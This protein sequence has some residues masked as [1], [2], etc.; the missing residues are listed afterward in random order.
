MAAAERLDLLLHGFLSRFFAI[1]ARQPATGAVTF[2]QMRVLWTLEPIQPATPGRIAGALGIGSSAATEI[3]ERLARAGYIQRAHSER[4][5]RHVLLRLSPKG[6]R[7]VEGF[8]VNR[9]SRLQKLL[10]RLEGGDVRRMSEALQTLND[11]VG[12]WKGA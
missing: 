3:V 4:D 9:Q 12:R 5:R 11:I 1:P 2:A 7:L 6:R 8:R 10:S